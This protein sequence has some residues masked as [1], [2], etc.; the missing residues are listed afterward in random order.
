MKRTFLLMLLF[1]AFPAACLGGAY[2]LDII[3]TPKAY[4]PF[5]GDM[6]FRFSIYDQGGILTSALLGVSDHV[7][8]GIYFDAGRFIGSEEVQMSPPGVLAR[9]LITDGM[10]TALPAIAVGYSYFMQG[11][12]SKIDGVIVS[13]LY[14]VASHRYFLFRSEQNFSYGLRYPV[15][16]FSHAQPENITAFAGTDIELSPAFSLKGEMENIRFV[17]DT[18]QE[19][20]YNFGFS[21]NILEMVSLDLAFKYSPAQDTLIRHLTIGYYTQF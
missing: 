6:H 1:A 11:E 3:D 7:F 2:D 17:Q 8:L 19:V 4:T 14:L 5:R 18:W 13:G 16:P 21:F 10:T 9:F 15:I 12:A 20:F